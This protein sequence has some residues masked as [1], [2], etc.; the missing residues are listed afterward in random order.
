MNLNKLNKIIKDRKLNP[1]KNSYVSNLF[2]EGLDRIAQKVGE[3]ATEVVIAAKNNNK[4]R[5]IEEMAD[6][7]FHSLV[8]LNE[9]TLS[10][11]DIFEELEKRHNKKK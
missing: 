4:Q 1:Q 10:P 9:K 8:L 7:W 6:L 11:E 2:E 5:F 3:E